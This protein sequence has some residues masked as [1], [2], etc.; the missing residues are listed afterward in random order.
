MIT[1]LKELYYNANFPAIMSAV[2]IACVGALI[3]IVK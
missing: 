3:F 2:I 1:K